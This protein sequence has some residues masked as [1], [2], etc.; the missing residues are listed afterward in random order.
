MLVLHN[1]QVNI[2]FYMDICF[3]LKCF[4]QFV[5]LFTCFVIAA[6][7]VIGHNEDSSSEEFFTSLH[8]KSNQNRI[9]PSD[10]SRLVNLLKIHCCLKIIFYGSGPDS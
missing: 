8:N 3:F 2:F 7:N 10:K 4:V 1:P 6:L 5:I 9:N